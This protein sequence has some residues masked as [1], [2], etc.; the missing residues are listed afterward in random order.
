[1]RWR[2]SATQTPWHW[3]A[4]E[5][6]TATVKQR[7]GGGDSDINV[8]LI[9][10]YIKIDIE[11]KQFWWEPIDSGHW[12]QSTAH[13]VGAI[14]PFFTFRVSLAQSGPQRRWVT[15]LFLRHARQVAQVP[16]R[17]T[18]SSTQRTE[19]SI[20]SPWIEPRKTPPSVLKLYTFLS[21]AAFSLPHS[22][23]ALTNKQIKRHLKWVLHEVRDMQK[24]KNAGLTK[25]K[26]LFPVGTYL[27]ANISVK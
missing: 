11:M 2:K 16:C 25:R 9:A 15:P 1:M 13:Q 22:F 3:H 27:H 5:D 23:R 17:A 4:K 12:P 26:L 24:M 19:P 21:S 18:N 8:G 6:A 20:V 10:F 7:S 14:S